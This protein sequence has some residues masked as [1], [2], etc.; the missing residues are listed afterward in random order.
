MADELS[1]SRRQP[2]DGA[3]ALTPAA[4]GAAPSRDGG[5]RRAPARGKRRPPPAPAADPPPA[6]RATDEAA[7]ERHLD[8]LV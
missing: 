7:H 6:D 3:S 2:T 4:S 8:M 5:G 1:I